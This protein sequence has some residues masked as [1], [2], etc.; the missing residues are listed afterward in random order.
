MSDLVQQILVNGFVIS[1]VFALGAVGFTLIFGVS[2][3]L[4]LSHGAIMVIGAMVAW[5]CTTR[6]GLGPYLG[7]LIGVITSVICTYLLFWLVVRP[8]WHSTRIIDEEKE[9]FILTATL[10][11]GLAVWSVLDHVFGSSPVSTMPMVSGVTRIGGV[12]LPLNS[13]VI[14]VIAWAALALV[15]YFVHRT[16]TGRALLAASMSPTGV[17]LMGVEVKRVHNIVWGLYGLIAGIAGVLLASLLGTSSASVADLTALAFSI[18]V[19][20]GLGNVLGSLFAAYIIGMA[21]TVTAY[22]ISPSLTDMPGL[23]LLILIMYV[24]PQGLFGRR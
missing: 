18:V 16:R 15:W 24:R 21:G 5:A 11:V 3:V 1:A 17:A 10:L 23:L 12:R 22:L 2:G 4:N 8:I 20:G 13:V 9:I 14:G 6:L 7:G 19:L